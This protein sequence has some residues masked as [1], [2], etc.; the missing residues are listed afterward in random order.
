M[1]SLLVKLF[2]KNPDEA[3]KPEVRNG[4]GQMAGFVGIFCNLLLFGGKIT[5]G[6]LAGSIAIMADA[7]NNLSDASSSVI[8]LIG[9]K[10]SAKPAD[11]KHPFGHAR[12]EYI[13][14]LAVAVLVLVIGIELGKSSIERILHPEPVA[15][16][17]VSYIVLIASIA[18]KFW[19]A[20]FNKKI[21]KII[22]SSALEATYADSRN[23]VIS[24]S[25]VLLAALIFQVFHINLDSWMGL[26]ISAF[27][28]VSGI[29]LVR[30]TLDP[31]LGEAPDPELVNTLVT[32]ITSYDGILGTH[33]LILHDYGPGRQFASAHVEMSKDI[34][35]M[36]SHDT[37]DCIERDIMEEYNIHIIIHYDPVIT[38]DA[39]INASRSKVESVIHQI[40]P[41]LTIHDFRIGEGAGR[42]N[43]FFD[44]VVPSE[45]EEE[46]DTLMD[47]IE[48]G[49][50]TG[51]KPI[52]TYI[53]IDISY[54]P[55]PKSG[56]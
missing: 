50:Q 42:I 45:L 21:G 36:K 22:Q 54:A 43:Y 56:Y 9:F 8:T 53:T 25:A 41:R 5:T 38:G 46:K 2:V 49:V 29:G 16:G 28:L 44:L 40:D 37:I 27:I 10:I 20:L 24:T 1:T 31:L 48:N 15:Y 33:D 30:E 19:M 51:D 11:D 18:V 12:S 34:D 13:A 3:H 47:K 17:V 55:V 14:G 4:Y 7:L 39:A 52:K 35:V 32:K 26:A 6:F 23:D